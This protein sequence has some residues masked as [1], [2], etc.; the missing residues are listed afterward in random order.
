LA[1]KNGYRWDS[2]AATC[3]FLE[4]DR[5]AMSTSLELG[6]SAAEDNGCGHVKAKKTEKS[7]L[8]FE[9]AGLSRFV[10]RS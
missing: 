6:E 5:L 4:F 1:V 8:N 10:S 7:L 3:F 9:M 2:D